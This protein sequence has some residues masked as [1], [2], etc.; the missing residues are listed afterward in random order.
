MKVLIT[1]HYGALTSRKFDYV[2]GNTWAQQLIQDILHTTYASFE[3]LIKF[4][5]EKYQKSEMHCL[6]WFTTNLSIITV[7]GALM[8]LNLW[9]CK[10]TTMTDIDL[11]FGVTSTGLYGHQILGLNFREDIAVFI[12]GGCV[13]NWLLFYNL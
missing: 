1:K 10:M 3:G 6:K 9:S 4:F 2:F 11:V 7:K 8:I 12:T 5:Y 13:Y